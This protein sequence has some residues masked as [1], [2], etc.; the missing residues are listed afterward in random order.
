[1]KPCRWI[2]LKADI[3]IIGGMTHGFSNE[4]ILRA[5]FIEARFRQRIINQAD[6]VGDRAFGDERV[7]AV[8]PTKS[9]QADTTPFGGVSIDIIKMG[10]A[11]FVFWVTK[12]GEAVTFLGTDRLNQG[13]KENREKYKRFE[14]E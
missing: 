9:R 7:E 6:I 10:K 13:R 8:K 5:G 4:T 11:L 12:Q 2:Q 1:M 3:G 14:G